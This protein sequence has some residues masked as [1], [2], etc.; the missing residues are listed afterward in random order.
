MMSEDLENW[1]IVSDFHHHDGKYGD[2]VNSSLV[3][4]DAVEVFYREG[5]TL[6]NQKLV[7]YT[8]GGFDV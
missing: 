3:V 6:N 8:L 5:V 4:G 7:C 1:S 2:R